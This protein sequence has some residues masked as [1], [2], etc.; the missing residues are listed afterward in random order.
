MGYFT[1]GAVTPSA[2]PGQSCN[3]QTFTVNGI[4]ETDNLGSIRPP[5]S[6]GN[7]SMNGYASG[8]NAVL[9]HFCNAAT[10]SAVPPAGAYT[11]LAM[12]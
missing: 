7:L 11:F 9:L 2:V 5:A 6:L 8:A 3:D 1:T 12:H 10:S 4:S